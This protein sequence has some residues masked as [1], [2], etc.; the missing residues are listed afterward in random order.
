MTSAELVATLDVAEAR[1]RTDE[2]KRDAEALWREMA[3]LFYDGVHEALG[4]SAWADYCEFEFGMASS[5]AH[6]L[7][8]SGRVLFAVESGARMR[9]PKHQIPSE[10]VAGVLASLLPPMNDQSAR[11]GRSGSEEQVAEA[12]SVVVAEHAASEQAGEPITSTLVRRIL[13]RRGVL[14]DTRHGGTSGTPNWSESLGHVGDDL[15]HA[16]KAMDKFD[17][18]I[19]ARQPSVKVKTNAARYAGWA[20]DLATRLRRVEGI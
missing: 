12:W 15:I 2:A 20:E 16:G 8:D 18:L 17:A 7:L 11:R 13:V 9:E 10:R 5:T 3:A 1:R 4:W 6:R 19:G 14:P